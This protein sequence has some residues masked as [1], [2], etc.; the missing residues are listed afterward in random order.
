MIDWVI[1]DLPAHILLVHFVVIVVPV[2]ALAVLMSAFWP[3][4]R[5][6][7]GIVTPIIALAALG[8]VP[9]TEKAGEWLQ[10]R[11]T[12]TPLIERHVELGETLT[13]WVIGLFLIALALW[14]WHRGLRTVP[15]RARI[16]VVVVM[17]VAAVALAIGAV[18]ATVIVG[19][20]GSA[21]VWTGSF[22]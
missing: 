12:S 5:R 13:P 20:S 16:A 9:L 17:D 1:G 19:E 2:A 14:W 4:A 15:P 11:V 21:A 3:A 10:G 8:S 18:V 7:L 6:R 22:R